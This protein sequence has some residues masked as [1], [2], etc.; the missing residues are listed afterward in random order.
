MPTITSALRV[1][2]L[3]VTIGAARS[4]SARSACSCVSRSVRTPS[5]AS[6]QAPIAAVHPSTGCIARS[7]ADRP[8]ATVHRTGRGCRCRPGS[9]ATVRCRAACP[10]PLGP[11]YSRHGARCSASAAGDRRR[12]SA[13]PAQPQG[14]AARRVHAVSERQGECPDRAQHHQRLHAAAREDAVEDLHHVERRREQRDVQH[15]A[16][17]ACQQHKRPQLRDEQPSHARSPMGVEKHFGLLLQPLHP[18]AASATPRAARLQMAEEIGGPG[19]R[20]AVVAG[21]GRYARL[22]SQTLRMRSEFVA[23]V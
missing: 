22:V 2:R 9:C 5:P 17:R 19:F 11:P 8:E 12:S 15:Q 6:R 20:R 13:R 10:T 21:L 14:A 16:R 7:R 3:G 23:L 1:E 18:S 4:R